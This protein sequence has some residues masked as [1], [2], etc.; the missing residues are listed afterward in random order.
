MKLIHGISSKRV[1]YPD[2]E[3]IVAQE[4]NPYLQLIHRDITWIRSGTRAGSAARI[5]RS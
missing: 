5:S 2:C 3:W 1:H 4:H